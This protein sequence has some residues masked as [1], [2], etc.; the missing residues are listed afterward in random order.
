[1]EGTRRCQSDSRDRTTPRA[2]LIG[3]AQGNLYVIALAPGLDAGTSNWHHRTCTPLRLQH[4][5]EEVPP[6]VE[7][8]L[9]AH[10]ALAEG[11]EGRD[12]LN[13]VGVQMLQLDPVIVQ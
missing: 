1:M 13:P 3:D 7:V 8:G 11:H 6:Q 10:V 9:A 5:S 4:T 2:L 12:L